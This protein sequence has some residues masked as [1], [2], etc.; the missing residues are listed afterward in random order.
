MPARECRLDGPEED[1]ELAIGGIEHRVE[2][3]ALRR[4]EVEVVVK[5]PTARV[6]G[7]VLL[8]EDA[9]C[10]EADDGAHEERA[11]Q[12]CE[13]L[14]LRTLH[15]DQREMSRGIV[16]SPSPTDAARDDGAMYAGAGLMTSA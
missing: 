5:R 7:V 6:F 4:G 13:G 10:R 2:R 11:E 15:G 12:E 14:L 9:I 3:D 16:A 1:L 8:P